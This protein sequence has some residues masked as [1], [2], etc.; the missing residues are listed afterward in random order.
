MSRSLALFCGMLSG[1]V[2]SVA[3][4]EPRGMIYD[5]GAKWC[6]PCQQVAPIVE[7]LER[8]GLP[9]RKIDIDEN[10]S[11]ADQYNVQSIPTFVLIIDGKE[12]DRHTGAMTESDL[13]RMAARIPAEPKNPAPTSGSPSRPGT[14]QPFQIQLGEPGPLTRP[15][16]LPSRPEE[17]RIVSNEEKK[18]G[19]KDLF[20]FGRKT[21]EKPATVRANNEVAVAAVP[22]A[23][24]VSSAFAADPMDASVRIRVITQQR[25]DLGSGTIISS[26]PGITQILTCAH[27]FK[28]YSPESKIEVDLFV[29]GQSSQYIGRLIKHDPESDL[30]LITIPMTNPVLPIKVGP[31]ESAPRMGEPLVA[32]GCSGG[33]NPT[34]QQSQVAAID[35]FDGPHNL[36]CT[37]L[38][39]QGRSGGGLFNRQGEIVGV[40]SAADPS[41]KEGFYSGLLAIHQLL[42][43]CE[44][45]SLYAPVDTTPVRTAETAVAAA[46]AAS[47]PVMEKPFPAAVSA[48]ASAPVQGSLDVQTGDAEVVVIIRD[49]SQPQSQNRVVIFHDISPKFY[50][51]LN[52]ELEAAPQSSTIL[53]QTEPMPPLR[54]I[55]R[56]LRSAPETMIAQQ[57]Q[58]LKSQLSPTTLSKPVPVQRFSRSTESKSRVIY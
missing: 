31:K 1:L 41:T 19:L 42:D 52:G 29:N 22:E 4:A 38:P 54:S 15:Q 16:S 8:A 6:G 20:S 12:V 27:I 48:P 46:P 58:S 28:E 23:T 39:V 14:N 30:G 3:M 57:P 11:L 13:R 17:T 40:C 32:I 45:T 55:T 21:E 50:A 44:L 37:G 25:I 53:S 49:K 56:Q 51:Y 9:I 5:F 2:A 24:A 36:L 34:R 10:R 43:Q 7:K 33:D 26:K 35:R 18:G 47:A